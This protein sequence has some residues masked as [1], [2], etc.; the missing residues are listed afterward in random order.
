ME[1]KKNQKTGTKDLDVI[2]SVYMITCGHCLKIYI[3]G[4]TNTL[5]VRL[6]EHKSNV[7][8]KNLPMPLH[9]HMREFGSNNIT[10]GLICEYRGIT[11]EDLLSREGSWVQYYNSTDPNVGFNLRI[12]GRG[13]RCEHKI[14]RTLCKLCKG[15]GICQHEKIRSACKLCKGGMICSHGRFKRACTVC[16]PVQCDI[17]QMAVSKNAYKAHCQTKNHLTKARKRE[18]F[19]KD[20]I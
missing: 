17:C 10:I 15:G 5:A 6:S 8:T 20:V 11:K 7:K 13:V 12:P 1:G 18:S 19:C 4:T 3:G 2:S 9:D 14:Q 16:S